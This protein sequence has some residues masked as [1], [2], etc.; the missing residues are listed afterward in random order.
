MRIR[1]HPAWLV[2][3]LGVSNLASAPPAKLPNIRIL[4]TGGTIAGA[5]KS[6]ED[7]GYK[8]GSFSV[9][10]LIAGV[11]ALKSLANLTGEQVCNIGSQDMNDA[12]WLQLADRLQAALDDPSV[13]GV[14]I[15]HGTDT[16]EETSYFLSLVTKSEKP[17]VLT[18][19]MRPATAI[20]ADG[21]M[22]LFNAVAVAADPASRDRGVLIL[23]NDEIFAAR[24]AQKMNTTRPDAFQAPNRG[25][26]GIANTGQVTFV[27]DPPAPGAQGV[28]S[29]AGLTA[30]PK[31]DIIYAYANMDV[32]LI[33]AAVKGGCQGLVLAGVGDGNASR[34]ALAA[35]SRAAHQGIAVVR[36]SRVGS[37]IVARD[38]EIDD[39]KLGFIAA[40]ELSPQKARIL[41]MLGLT[42]T[43]DPAKLQEYFLTL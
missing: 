14:V 32:G 24:D 33:D 38:M 29:V 35:L 43:K 5:Q 2:V 18:G 3:A 11:P 26:I 34:P 7:A 12:I 19:A 40:Q 10:N 39:D 42:K 27:D 6:Q 4:A 41:L 28:F 9:E 22:N 25:S 1:I 23:M 8:A 20:S 36:S 17:V 16:M 37:G 21:P 15:T 31:V 13:D 30:L